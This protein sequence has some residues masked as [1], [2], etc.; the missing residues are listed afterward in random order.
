MLHTKK[1]YNL[2][3]EKEDKEKD[4]PEKA[5]NVKDKDLKARK[6]LYSVDNQIDAL[7]LRYENSSI[8]EEEDEDMLA[9]FSMFKNSLRFLLEQEE[10][11]LADLAGD[12]GGEAA[13]GDAAGGEGEEEP[14]DSADTDTPP[15]GGEKQAADKPAD[16]ENIPDLDVDA[17]TSR[18]V[19][20]ISNPQNLL[21]L[22]TAIVNR[23]KNF[24]DEHYGDEFVIRFVNTL[25]DEYGIEV[26]EFDEEDMTQVNNDIFA[27]GAKDSGGG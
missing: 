7:I 21:D 4:A 16:A 20:L 17:F 23:I 12:A 6:S 14:G 26:T 19:R 11:P 1:I 9:E 13:G 3:F 2:L 18:A 8:R 15:T 5:V 22:E 10:D 27:P 24:L 25:R